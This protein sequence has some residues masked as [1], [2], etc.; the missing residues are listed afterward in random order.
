VKV[1]HVNTERTWRGGEQQV[2]YLLR[3]LRAAGVEQE[4]LCQPDGVLAARAR[5]QG[6]A[7]W[8]R[9][10][11][12][13]VDLPAALAIAGRIRARRFD[14]VH[15]HTS[16]A[17][18]L[19]VLGAVLSGRPRPV[20]VVARRVDFSIHKRPVLDF[21]RQKYT[22]GVDRILCVSET[23]RRVLIA[24]GLP[25]ALLGVVHS[26]IDLSR[27]DAVP[28]RALD[29]RRE[30]GVPRDGPLIL[31]VAHCADHK[32]QRYLVAA[33][34]A[35]LA[36]HPGARIVIAG[37]GELLPALQAQAAE[38]GL[39]ERVLFP[40]FRTDVPALLRACDLFCFP[41]HL[42][43]LGT[44]VLDALARGCPIVSTT[45]GGIPEMIVRGVHGLLVPPRDP[46]ALAAGMLWMLEHPAEARAMGA[47]GRQR[48]ERD[49][50]CE[51]TAQ[52]TLAEYGRLLAA[53]RGAGEAGAG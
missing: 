13:E 32:G 5:E 7:V 18:T 43:G 28:D 8:P 2:L 45:A 33:A 1:L 6:V 47:A 17:H 52:R 30:F 19:G 14:I 12:G 36:H 53:R 31:N 10:M 41:S 35:L 39:A 11:R 51:R 42:E 44:S 49:F 3:G 27:L 26:G 4:L 23:I 46:A 34:P 16:H 29:Y 38:L 48:V 50:T 25:E 9:R 15:M 37:E 20:T 24:D 21:S 40:G 22:W